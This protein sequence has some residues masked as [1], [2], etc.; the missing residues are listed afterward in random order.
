MTVRLW[1]SR[2]NLGHCNLGLGILF[3]NEFIK[4]ELESEE[5]HSI[6]HFEG[7][8]WRRR[9]E[10]VCSGE[11]ALSKTRWHESQDNFQH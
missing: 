4:G 1:E 8:A 7:R 2:S 11:G 10:I 9:E 6:K 3:I 5:A